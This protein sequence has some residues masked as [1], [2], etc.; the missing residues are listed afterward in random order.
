[1]FVD[2]IIGENAIKKH[3]KGVYEIYLN[4][5]SENEYK[6]SRFESCEHQR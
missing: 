5:G 2:L 6:R 3:F 4:V 1:M